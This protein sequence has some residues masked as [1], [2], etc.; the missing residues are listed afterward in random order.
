M[1]RQ[2]LLTFVYC[3]AVWFAL[4]LPAPAAEPKVLERDNVWAQDYSD[5][6]A[7]PAVRF[8]TLPNGMR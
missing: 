6:K 8:G 5:V 4:A 7:D 1:Q 3:V 2:R